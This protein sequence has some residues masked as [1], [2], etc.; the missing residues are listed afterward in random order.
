MLQTTVAC[1]SDRLEKSHFTMSLCISASVS[2]KVLT[3]GCPLPRLQAAHVFCC[4][5][6]ASGLHVAAAVA[7]NHQSLLP[8]QEEQ[9]ATG[10]C[11]ICHLSQHLAQRTVN[12]PRARAGLTSIIAANLLLFAWR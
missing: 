11:G 1:A 3:G 8:A 7:A 12:L 5:S 9:T 4:S 6:I 2:G 10:K